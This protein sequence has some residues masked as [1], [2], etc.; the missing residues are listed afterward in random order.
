MGNTTQC[1]AAS[2]S[3]YEEIR[4][5]DGLKDKVNFALN[6]T[7]GYTFRLAF[8]RP[9]G[10]T[11]EIYGMSVSYPPDAAGNRDD[12]VPTIIETALLGK[13][14]LVESGNPDIHDA[15]L[16]YDENSGYYDV[17]RFCN[18]R[19]LVEEIIRIWNYLQVVEA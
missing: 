15:E 1:I 2:N 14:P 18:A 3:L 17:C 10:C 13:I 11:S 7:D 12:R 5:H 9:E 16:L 4:L 19:E 6:N 8:I